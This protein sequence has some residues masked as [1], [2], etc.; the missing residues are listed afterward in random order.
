MRILVGTLAACALLGSAYAELQNVQVYGRIDIRARYYKNAFNNAAVYGGGPAGQ[1]RIPA[2][3]LPGRPIGNPLGVVGAFD[4]DD[5]GADWG[6]TELVT[7]LGVKADLTNN[8]N[9]VIEFYDFERW[10]GD[11][12][13]RSNYITGADTAADTSNDVELLQS[14]IEIS[15]IAGTPLKARIGRQRMRFDEG[16]LV[17]DQAT[18]TLRISW[19][20]VLLNYTTDQFAVDAFATKLAENSPAEEDGDVDFYGLRAAYTA[21]EKVDIAAWWYWVRDARGLTDTNLSWTA[22]W[23]EELAGV[24]DYDPTNLHTVGGRAWGNW[25][26]LDY[27]LKLAYQFGNADALGYLFK[28]DVYGDDDAEWDQWAGDLEIGYTLD[29]PWKPRP[30]AL[31]VYIGGQDNRDISFREWLS[32]FDKPE[33]SASFNRLFSETNYAPACNDNGCMTNFTELALGVDVKPLEKVFV[34]T[35]VGRYWVNEPFDWP[36]YFN[37]GRYRV[38]IA[39]SLSFWTTESGDDIGWEWLNMVRY[40]YSGNLTVLLFYS[41]FFVD[42]DHGLDGNYLYSNGLGFMGGTDDDDADYVFLWLILNF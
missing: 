9:G 19:D 7:T 39:P 28:P 16:W 34:K 11:G 18:P 36:V 23:L 22:E 1:V 17:S 27:D 8:V 32:P 24:D 40:A 13:F 21:L 4:Y 5:R 3:L 33:A 42:E 10:G 12:D 14:Y 30:Y 41:H 6:F 37:V 31:G 35:Q 29:V 38:P 25:G 20:G 15:E 2:S 26:A